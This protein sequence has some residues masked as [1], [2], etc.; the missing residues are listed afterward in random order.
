MLLFYYYS[1]LLAIVVLL[2]YTYSNSY[3]RIERYYFKNDRKLYYLLQGMYFILVG[4][5]VL[6][7]R[8]LVYSFAE[9]IKK[10]YNIGS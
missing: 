5:I 3:Q 9:Q 7:I 2:Y 8:Y 4:A 10:K 1:L 6:N